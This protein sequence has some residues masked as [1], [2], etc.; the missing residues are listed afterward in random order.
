MNHKP[1]SADAYFAKAFAPN[2]SNT[3]P[4]KKKISSPKIELPKN[5]AHLLPLLK[6]KAESMHMYTNALVVQILETYLIKE[7][8]LTL[9]E[10]CT[11]SKEEENS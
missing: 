5:K 10:K 8:L 9:N 4:K 2:K 1:D 7:E 11:D 6:S 3:T